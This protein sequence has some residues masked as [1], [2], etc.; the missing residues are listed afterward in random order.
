MPPTREPERKF[1]PGGK[2]W[3]RAAAKRSRA[4]LP[5]KR[6]RT[7]HEPTKKKLQSV[8]M[9]PHLRSIAGDKILEG[10]LKSKHMSLI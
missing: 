6:A 1:D 8:G 9:G 4:R 10:V 3:Q 5:S 2:T 7:F